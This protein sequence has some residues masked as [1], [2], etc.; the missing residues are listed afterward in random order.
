[1]TYVP[2]DVR[3]E[4]SFLDALCR[5]PALVERARAYRFEAL[6]VA[7]EHSVLALPRFALAAR[8][9]GIRPLLGARLRLHADLPSS[10]PWG[11]AQ[12]EMLL[13]ATDARGYGN[14]LQL[15]TL[16][17]LECG[18][19]EPG[20]SFEDLDNARAGLLA[21]DGGHRG[22]LCGTLAQSGPGTAARLAG[23]LRELFGAEDF[24]IQMQRHGEHAEIAMEPHL[25]HLARTLNVPVV[26]ANE[27]RYLDAEEARQYEVLRCSSAGRALADPARPALRPR[28]HLRSPVEMQSLFRDLPEALAN[29]RL[30][31]ERCQFE[32]A[33]GIA[34]EFT[35]D[36]G[37]HPLAELRLQCE[38]G[39]CR[40]YGMLRYQ[41]VPAT[42]RDRIHHELAKIAE[43]K[44]ASC[45][46]LAQD[47]VRYASEE[48]VPVGPGRGGLAGSLVAFVLGLTEVDPM[49]HGLRCEPFLAGSTV[50]EFE[51]DVAHWGHERLLHGVQRR[52]GTER[53][54]RCGHVERLSAR[55]AVRMAATAL[56]ADPSA[57]AELDRALLHA[58]PAGAGGTRG[59]SPWRRTAQTRAILEQAIRLEGLAQR[60]VASHG[61]MLVGPGPMA[62]KVALQRH[63]GGLHLAQA[64]DED[65]SL[66][67]L[68]R[69]HLEPARSVSLVDHAARL[70][71]T[72]KDRPFTLAGFTLDDERTYRQLAS[73][74]TLGVPGLESPRAQA[75]LK[76]LQPA[77]FDALVTAL[78]LEHD[79]GWGQEGQNKIARGPLSSGWPELE[80]L[81]QRT[82]GFLLF[83]EQAVEIA[84]R[85]AGYDDEAAESLRTAICRRDWGNL[86]RQ[87]PAFLTGAVERGAEVGQAEALFAQLVASQGALWSRAR[88]TAQALFAYQ[89]AFFSAHAPEEFFTAL[90]DLST[91]QTGRADLILREAVERQIKLL[92]VDIQRSQAGPTLEN[93]SMR[94][95][96]LQVRHVGE[97][98]AARIVVNRCEHGPF[99]T[100]ED[101]RR[102][103]PEVPQRATASLVASGAFESMGVVRTTTLSPRRDEKQRRQIAAQQLELGFMAALPG[104]EAAARR[105]ENGTPEHLDAKLGARHRATM[106]RAAV[107]VH[108]AQ[109]GQASRRANAAPASEVA[110]K[111]WIVGRIRARA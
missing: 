105:T 82:H 18:Q 92:D 31:A 34:P 47:V 93:G 28:Q 108:S 55:G 80:E 51:F 74:A 37:R 53:V 54:A 62:A 39:A 24:F 13:Y 23:R 89:A 5:V 90:L 7:D 15:V 91:G 77:R 9:A 4:Y 14:L 46:L 83:E 48:G 44:L 50:P 69:L 21:L 100:L 35:T 94:L 25:L 17:H 75:L 61:R 98:L 109:L 43:K 36:S 68:L 72:R 11:S 70:V 52:L 71:A 79:A 49:L 67:G 19:G 107:R 26:A 101:F 16:A 58:V 59:S 63:D 86:G 56:G 10:A 22:P 2:L 88:T 12:P 6:G 95:G 42:A 106:G 60:L 104:M 66:L 38:R 78:A 32:L 27:T 41:D 110:P 85:L 30:V 111:L 81:L 65:A 33:P 20:V 3:T 87:R 29:T 103:L 76:R 1:M 84:T 40:R 96:L 45:F 57:A 99:T 8:A 102:R 64:T 73:G 97:S